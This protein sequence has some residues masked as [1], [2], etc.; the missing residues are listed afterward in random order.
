MGVTC[1]CGQEFFDLVKMQIQVREMAQQ[2]KALAWHP[3]TTC[4]LN[5]RAET[6]DGVRKRLEA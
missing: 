2:V 4:N 6:G 3:L 5:T 1:L